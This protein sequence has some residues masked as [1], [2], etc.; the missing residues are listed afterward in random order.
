M[1]EVALFAQAVEQFHQKGH[2]ALAHAVAHDVLQADRLHLCLKSLEVGHDVSLKGTKQPVFVPE[3]VV[4]RAAVE[5]R[6]SAQVACGEP[7]EP[8]FLRQ[9]DEGLA[10]RLLRSRDSPIFRSGTFVCRTCHKLHPPF[11][12]PTNNKHIVQ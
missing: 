10:Q 5:P 1:Q 4:E 2:R 7:V 9:L 6:A 11:N 12:N 3:D 8:A